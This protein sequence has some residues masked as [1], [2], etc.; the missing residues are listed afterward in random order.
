MEHR[1]TGLKRV[2]MWVRIVLLITISLLLFG[3]V[4]YKVFAQETTWQTEHRMTAVETRVDSMA[5]DIR[6]TRKA[7]DDLGRTTW[8]QLL[9]LSGLIGER[10][11]Q[12]LK[13]KRKDPE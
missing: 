2:A 6:D 1:W 8:M 5:Q 3:A 4:A 10:G 7:V 13:N 12:V 9:A 11:L